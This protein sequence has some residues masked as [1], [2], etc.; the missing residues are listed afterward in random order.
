L[1]RKKKSLLRKTAG[2]RKLSGFHLAVFD[3]T[4]PPYHEKQRLISAASPF[5]RRRKRLC[6][7]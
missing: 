5:N 4:A 6:G 3:S 2:N 7:L 1:G